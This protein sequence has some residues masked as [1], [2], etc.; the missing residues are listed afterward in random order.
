GDTTGAKKPASERPPL[1]RTVS[2]HILRGA[3]AVGVQHR[4]ASSRRGCNSRHSLLI[5]VTVLA[6]RLIVPAAALA[7]VGLFAASAGFSA[8]TVAIKRTL[9]VSVTGKGRLVSTPRGINC[10]TTC[11]A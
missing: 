4:V 5:V 11:S 1:Q 9:T 2:C 10:K 8:S 7:A 3:L 6:R